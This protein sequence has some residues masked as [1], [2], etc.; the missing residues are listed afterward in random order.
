MRRLLVLTVLIGGIWL[1]TATAMLGL[2]RREKPQPAWVIF[3]S[4][5]TLYTISTTGGQPITVGAANSNYRPTYVLHTDGIWQYYLNDGAWYRVRPIYPRPQKLPHMEGQSWFMA[6]S[7]DAEWLLFQSEVSDVHW[8][9]NRIRSDGAVLE[10]LTSS[11]AFYRFITLSPDQAWIYYSDYDNG[12]DDLYRMRWD[13]SNQQLVAA[14]IGLLRFLGWSERDDHMI[15]GENIDDDLTISLLNVENGN[16]TLLID[17]LDFGLPEVSGNGGWI[18]YRQA[19]QLDLILMR[20]DGNDR[21][22]VVGDENYSFFAWTPDE[23][24]MLL[25]RG[26]GDYPSLISI[27]LTS[28]KTEAVIQIS[29]Q[30]LINPDYWIPESECIGYFL[31]GEEYNF[32]RKAACLD[33]ETTYPLSPQGKSTDIVFWLPDGTWGIFAI[34]DEYSC[35]F[36]RVSPDGLSSHR[37]S[38]FYENII[39]ATL[40]PLI[41]LEWSRVLLTTIAILLIFVAMIWQSRFL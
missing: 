40:L 20:S 19:G 10:T 26:H 12:I 11:D 35:A 9:L 21:R 39:G 16:R 14:D 13:G 3:R 36:Y 17:D 38:P 32:V 37:I 41:D 7:P 2:A 23:Q 22:V 24:H 18:V 4:E 25:Y 31:L 5:D 30:D 28:G 6:T 33:T 1:L 34:C 15:V 27:Q 8:D 29:E